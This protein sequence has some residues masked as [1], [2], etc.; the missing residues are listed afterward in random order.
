MARVLKSLD[1]ERVDHGLLIS[2][3]GWDIIGVWGW[4]HGENFPLSTNAF[5]SDFLSLLFSFS[6]STLD[7]E[8]QREEP[9][10]KKKKRIYFLWASQ[11]SQGRN[12]KD[13]KKENPPPLSPSSFYILPTKEK[14]CDHPY[15]FDLYVSPFS[16]R[17]IKYYLFIYFFIHNIFLF[18]FWLHSLYLS[19]SVQ[20]NFSFPNFCNS[21]Y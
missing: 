17:N 10:V 13:G 6:S 8:D 2:W 9:R 5:S 4:I 19:V 16:S 21:K 12:E 20:S 11:F 15:T 1:Q 3:S 14:G 18:G 7:A